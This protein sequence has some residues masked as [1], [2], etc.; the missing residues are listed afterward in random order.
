MYNVNIFD[1]W[2]NRIEEIEAVMAE[3]RKQTVDIPQ[4]SA[5]K[6]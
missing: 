2:E 3:G 1:D 5:K 4:L 6:P